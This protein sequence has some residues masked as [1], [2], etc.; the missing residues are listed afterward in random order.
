ME[1][2]YERGTPPEWWTDF[3]GLLVRERRVE[4]RCPRCKDVFSQDISDQIGI[5]FAEGQQTLF[6]RLV[7]SCA[8]PHKGAP[9]GTS[10]CGAEGGALV[11]S[12]G[13]LVPAHLTVEQV[14]ADVYLSQALK[15]RLPRARAA[16]EKW[17]ATVSAL[18]AVFGASVLVFSDD[19]IRSL[20]LWASVAFGVLT[21][22][23][24][25]CAAGSIIAA[26]RAAHD[27]PVT[28]PADVS[29]RLNLYDILFNKTV[30][31]LTWS[32]TLA[33]LAGLLFIVSLVLRWYGP[34]NS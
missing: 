5:G 3:D 23:A 13:K 30:A 32:R 10:G 25:G 21:L 4:G 15:D 9:P 14:A 7:C 17:G 24:L 33:L 20:H 27:Q 26:A 2:A 11:F 22:L 31:G 1:K 6:V 16:A 19:M 29:E 18:T 12:D 34:Q 28:I 8:R